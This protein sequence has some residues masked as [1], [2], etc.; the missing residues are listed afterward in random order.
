LAA[1]PDLRIMVLRQDETPRVFRESEAAVFG[2]R[3]LRNRKGLRTDRFERRQ[4]CSSEHVVL[5]SASAHLT[6]LSFCGAACRG[7]RRS[8]DKDATDVRDGNARRRA[9]PGGKRRQNA[10]PRRALVV[11]SASKV[12][13]HAPTPTLLATGFAS[14]QTKFRSCGRSQPLDLAIYRRAGNGPAKLRNRAAD[15]AGNGTGNGAGIEAMRRR[16]RRQR[17]KTC[18]SST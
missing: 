18:T 13:V 1:R 9:G 11:R 12:R 16:W 8:N 4:E 15:G 7:R 5:G 10:I 14:R 2:S 6:P 17:T 3:A